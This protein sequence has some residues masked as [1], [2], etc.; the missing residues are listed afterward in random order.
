MPMRI[1]LIDDDEVD[2][3]A[4]RRALKNSELTVEIEEASNAQSAISLFDESFF[5]CVLLDYRLPDTDGI[6]VALDL[7]DRNKGPAVP[8]VMLT[9]EGNETVAVDAMKSG[10]QDYLP[11]S[12]LDSGNLA[13]AI[14]NAVEKTTLHNKIE[15]MNKTFEHMALNDSLTGLGN[16][17]LFGDRLNNLIATCKRS[18]EPFSLLMMDLNKFKEVNDNHGHEAGD[19]VLREVGNRLKA[20]GR[21]ADGFFRLGGDEFAAL[22]T[23]GVTREG[24]TII[25]KR[26]LRAFKAP[27]DFNSVPLE[28][29]VSI[30]IVLFP[31]HG[32]VA[33]ELLRLADAAMY[34][35][36]RGQ[37]GFSIPSVT[38]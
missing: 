3:M 9:G 34:E 38:Q 32:E 12:S 36:K 4:V 21:D 27:I 20:I 7:L 26:I 23:T 5:D 16:R 22:L 13:R 6:S 14:N 33:D 1:L 28:T 37:L 8:I 10:V 29:G 2:R 15:E 11:K 24:V 19:E 18:G 25:A 30:G 17:N 35:A 31:E